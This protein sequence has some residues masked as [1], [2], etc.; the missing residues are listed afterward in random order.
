MAEGG[1]V[2]WELSKEN[3]QPLRRGRNMSSLNRA[4]SQL[5]DG[6]ST[7]INQQ[8]Q[9][10]LWPTFL[11]NCPFSV[12]SEQIQ[13]FV[14]MTFGFSLRFSRAFESEL[15]MYDGDDPLDVWHRYVK[16]ERSNLYL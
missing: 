14:I 8:R 5:H 7:A 12:S 13:F 15:R 2:E 1:E 3:I 9:Y 11:L 6:D 10:E 4:L 16:Y